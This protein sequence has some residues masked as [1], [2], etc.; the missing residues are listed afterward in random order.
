M[1]I[2]TDAVFWSIAMKTAVGLAITGLIGVIMWPIRSV[3]KEWTSLKETTQ[4]IKEE[5]GQQRTNCL[6]TLQ[7]QGKRQ[8]ELL[9]DVAKT[10]SDI[11]LSQAEMTGY[12]KANSLASSCRPR[13][14]KK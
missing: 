14:K 3:R 12:C 5:L 7:D 4:A 10:L 8:I 13:A 1:Q 11:H 9:G 2:N 6:N